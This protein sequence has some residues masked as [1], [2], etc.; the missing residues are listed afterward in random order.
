MYG[1]SLHFIKNFIHILANQLSHVFSLS[2]QSGF[3]PVQLKFAKVIPIF[4]SG[5]PQSVDNYRTIS[6]L[7]NFSKILEKIVS[8][9]LTHF[10][11]SN[12]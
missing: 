10:L 12:M 2:L 1:I 4:K 11:E 8:S 3:V 9:R 6:L 7:Y 5:D